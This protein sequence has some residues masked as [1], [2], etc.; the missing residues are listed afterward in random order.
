MLLRETV[1]AAEGLGQGSV[2][3]V[4]LE[5]ERAS[6]ALIPLKTSCALCLLLAPDAIPGQGIFEARR[7]ASALDQAL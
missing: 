4:L 3:D 1:A 6:L 2:T 5:A 7:A